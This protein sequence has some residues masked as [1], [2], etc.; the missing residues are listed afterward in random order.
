MSAITEVVGM[1]ARALAQE[2]R[3]ARDIEIQ[4]LPVRPGMHARYLAKLANG[5]P[6][7]SDYTGHDSAE[8]AVA[9][10]LRR[11]EER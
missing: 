6:C 10:I 1:V 11:L 9:H 8:A 3:S 2:R 7:C 4:I 5:W